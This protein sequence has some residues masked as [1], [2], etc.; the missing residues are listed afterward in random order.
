[1][2]DSNNN[3]MMEEQIRDAL[4]SAPEADFERWRQEHAEALQFLNRT[5]SLVA[6]ERAAHRWNVAVR[7]VTAM[8]AALALI[9]TFTWVLAPQRPTFAQTI[10]G[11]ETAK[12]VTWVTTYYNRCVSADGN[13]TWLRSRQTK[14]QYMHPGLYRIENYDHRGR[15]SQISIKDTVRRER[16]NL[17]MKHRIYELTTIESRKARSD[18]PFVWVNEILKN[19][20]IEAAGERMVDGQTVSVFRRRNL[21]MGKYHPRNVED[22]WIDTKTKQLVG[23]SRPSSIVFDPEALEYRN[24]PPEEDF[25]SQLILGSVTKDI[26]LDAEVDPELFKL[27]IPEGFAKAK[28][29]KALVPINEDDLIEWLQITAK[30]NDG[31]FLDD[32]S[33]RNTKK[34]A[35]ALYKPTEVRTDDEKEMGRIKLRHRNNGNGFPFWD[36]L[37]QN[38]VVENFKYVGKGVKLGSSDIIILWYQLK[39]TGQFRAVYG[40]LTIQDISSDDLPIP[41]K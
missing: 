32:V 38:T 18:G 20:P 39:T 13:R 16:L 34:I 4:G 6:A 30:V 12:A 27:T 25:S 15:I 26:V 41:L 40:D 14:N 9:F 35:E 1:M 3:L 17:D 5:V 37:E 24:N 2:N 22:I 19:E 33:W 11:V 10:K 28:G 8:A 29:P 36:F 31:T 7:V 23:L 21:A